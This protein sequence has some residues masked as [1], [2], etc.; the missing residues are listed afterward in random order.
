MRGWSRGRGRAQVVAQV[1][2]ELEVALGGG[3]PLVRRVVPRGRLVKVL[4]AGL[5]A[6]AGASGIDRTATTGQ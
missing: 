1:L 2:P 3:R 6:E 5:R 4:H